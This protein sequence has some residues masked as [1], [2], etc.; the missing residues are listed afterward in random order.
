ML[1]LEKLELS[2][3]KATVSDGAAPSLTVGF[4]KFM[5]TQQCCNRKDLRC[6]PIQITTIIL[7]F[8]A[9][10]QGSTGSAAITFNKKKTRGM[11]AKHS[12]RQEY[13]GLPCNHQTTR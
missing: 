3:N 12:K 4:S 6:V 8:T 10:D 7:I 1:I 5:P 2:Y 9:E 11:V 13:V